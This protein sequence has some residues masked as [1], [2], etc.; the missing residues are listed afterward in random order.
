MFNIRHQKPF[1]L[2]KEVAL[3]GER[4]RVL[5]IS[6]IFSFSPL[7][8]CAT[9]VPQASKTLKNTLYGCTK[10]DGAMF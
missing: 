10:E 6:F 3:G 9:A 2:K 4:T 1:F 8:C 7:Y 5:L